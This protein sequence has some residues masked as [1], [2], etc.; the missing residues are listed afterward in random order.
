MKFNFKKKSLILWSIAAIAI[1]IL[2]DSEMYYQRYK[3]KSEKLPELYKSYPTLDSLKDHDYEII[4]L[5]RGIHEPVIQENDSTIVIITKRDHDSKKEGADNIYTWYKINLKGQITDSLQYQYNTENGI[6]N[7]Q[8][9]NDYIVDVDQNTY[10]N[11]LKDGDT[12]HYPYK[13]LNEAKIFSVAETEDII[14]DRNY[15]YDDIIHSESP[16]NEYKYKLTVFKDNVW[17]YFYAEKEWHGYPKNAPNK[18]AIN[19]ENSGYEIDKPSGL[20]KREHVQKE[21]WNA[22]TF[23]SLKNLS[24]GTGNGSGHHGWTGT[25]Y[26]SI[27]MPKKTLHYKQD[28][29]IE[30]PDNAVH[31]SFS[32]FVYQ[33]KNGDYMLLIDEEHQLYYLIRPKKPKKNNRF[34]DQI[35]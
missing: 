25:S 16:G 20:I 7:Y 21:E 6:H 14:A 34:E 1:I 13:N 11:W 31:D 15:M 32:Y 23:W 33:P 29:F 12:T 28:V 17:N 5:S 10:S 19:Y 26:F 8:T 18:K 9:F 27:K 4:K 2:P 3:L 35:L 30:H 22:H 24:W